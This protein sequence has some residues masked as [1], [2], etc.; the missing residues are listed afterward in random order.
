[1]DWTRRQ[2]F[3]AQML[4]L[5]GRTSCRRERQRSVERAV[6]GR[7]R[8]SWARPAAEP[9][10]TRWSCWSGVEQPR[11]AANPRDS[12]QHVLISGGFLNIPPSHI[13]TGRAN[14]EAQATRPSNTENNISPRIQ[15]G[16]FPSFSNLPM[17]SQSDSSQ[18]SSSRPLQALTTPAM[19]RP[20]S[21]RST[22]QCIHE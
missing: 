4:H 10:S 3:V 5:L 20:R 16:F 8:Q 19:P 12:P 15:P 9:G 14:A 11:S 7:P 2:A 13:S 18:R 1:M 21:P 22:V 17:H 6:K